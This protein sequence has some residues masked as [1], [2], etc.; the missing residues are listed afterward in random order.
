MGGIGEKQSRILPGICQKR[1]LSGHPIL[2]F[3]A[4]A[5]C[6]LEIDANCFGADAAN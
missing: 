5:D 2:D 1:F 4:Q 3:D 6:G